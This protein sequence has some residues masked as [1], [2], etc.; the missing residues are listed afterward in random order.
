M[1]FIVVCTARATDTSVANINVLR[2]D[3]YVQK[4]S[5]ALA[6][7]P[8]ELCVIPSHRLCNTTK[9]K[10]MSNDNNHG[11]TY[12]TV[13]NETPEIKLDDCTEKVSDASTSSPF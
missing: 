13:L 6:R 12:D 5:G 10:V 7:S 3:D 2:L 4:N 11:I 8:C 1:F 9:Q